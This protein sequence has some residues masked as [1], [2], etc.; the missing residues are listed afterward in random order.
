MLYFQAILVQEKCSSIHQYWDIPVSWTLSIPFPIVE[1]T[2]CEQ[3]FCNLNLSWLW[4]TSMKHY[5]VK[6]HSSHR[7]SN[8]FLHISKKS[9]YIQK[10]ANA[11]TPHQCTS[12]LVILAQ[13]SNYLFTIPMLIAPKRCDTT[14]MKQALANRLIFHAIIIAL[15]PHLYYYSYKICVEFGRW[16]SE[17]IIDCEMNCVVLCVHAPNTD[18]L[19]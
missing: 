14:A 9:N 8:M 19:P 2:I 16:Y 1:N 3:Y 13:M 7:L 17:L 4:V 11:T 12:Y 15:S 5:C 6:L 18:K 10:V